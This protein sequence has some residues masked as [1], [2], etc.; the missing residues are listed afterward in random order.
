MAK[1]F[2]TI[3]ST[4]LMLI[5]SVRG[6]AQ[7][8]VLARPTSQQLAFQDLELGV[9]IHYSIDTYATHNAPQ[10]STLPSAFN[11]TELNPEQ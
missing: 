11:P 9:F 10:G 4:L 6:W 5:A 1:K 8:S 3:V 2:M 7:S